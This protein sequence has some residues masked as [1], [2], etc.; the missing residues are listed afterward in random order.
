MTHSYG[1]MMGFVAAMLI[2]TGGVAQAWDFFEHCLSGCR[3][4]Q[5]EPELVDLSVSDD[6][7]IVFRFASWVRICRRVE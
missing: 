3:D 4:C 7:V 1:K 2:G 6:G 5:R